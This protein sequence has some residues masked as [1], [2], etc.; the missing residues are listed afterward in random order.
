MA[1]VELYELYGE[2]LYRFA[3]RLTGSSHDA[4]DL[5]QETFTRALPRLDRLDPEQVNLEAYLITT[6]KNVYLKGAKRGR[7][8]EL[9]AEPPEPDAPVPVDVDP[10]VAA[11]LTVQQEDVRRANARLAPRQRLALA[12]REL[13][14]KSYAEIGVVVG[15]SENA[16]AQLISRARARLRAELRLGEVDVESAP[17]R[18]RRYLAMLSPYLDGQLKDP[19]REEVEHHLRTCPRCKGAFL[20][21]QETGAT[22]RAII[23]PVAFLAALQNRVGDALAAS[24]YSQGQQ[25]GVL[26]HLP[27]RGEVRH[28]VIAAAAVAA[29]AVLSIGAAVAAVVMTR[30][31]GSRAAVPAATR[32]ALD[33]SAGS[34]PSP[35]ISAGQSEDSPTAAPFVPPSGEETSPAGGASAT[36]G[37]GGGGARRPAQGNA[38][39]A[40]PPAVLAVSAATAATAANSPATSTG[41]GSPPGAGVSPPPRAG[42]PAPPE[43]GVRPPGAGTAPPSSPSPSPAPSAPAPPSP[44]PSPPLRPRRP[45]PRPRPRRLRPRRRRPRRPRR[46]RLRR[47]RRRAHL[48]QTR[49]LRRIRLRRLTLLRLRPRVCR[50]WW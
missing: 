27:R 12:L 2:R 42:G 31:E 28:G 47:R 7:R 9:T 30:D 20:L 46:R 22:Y 18:C 1:W 41:A 23:L 19:E 25:T 44:A 16:V 26:A 32:T 38:S 40:Q 15:L 11:L 17:E 3:Y 50:T 14:G 49:I 21:F 6:A 4:S 13:E 48:P 43:P 33:G 37:G 8:L 36:G 39:S 45:R 34:S 35:V 24:G 10:E 5:V 29:L